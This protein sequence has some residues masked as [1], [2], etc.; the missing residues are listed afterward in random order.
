MELS[1]ED[2][3]GAVSTGVV[4][5]GADDSG[6]ETA[7]LDCAGVVSAGEVSTGVVSTDADDA[8]TDDSGTSMAGLD[9]AGVEEAGG[10][11]PAS[12]TGQTVVETA[13]TEVTTLVEDAGQLVIVGAQ[14]VTVKV[15]V[16]KIVE[17]VIW[18]EDGDTSA[19]GETSVEDAGTDDRISELGETSLVEG[20]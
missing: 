18:T 9:C 19:V 12:L 17:V 13:I 5:N 6:T 11:L 8:G 7:G 15:A 3:T 2:S 14:D 20:T 16:L 10:T 4:E 1:A